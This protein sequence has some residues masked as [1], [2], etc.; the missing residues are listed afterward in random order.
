MRK[1][2]N[3]RVKFS[4]VIFI[5]VGSINPKLGRVFL[6]TLEKVVHGVGVFLQ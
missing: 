6:V 4:Q 1:C 3:D 5:K 2:E